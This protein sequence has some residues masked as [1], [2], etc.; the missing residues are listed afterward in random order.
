MLEFL[1]FDKT[2]TYKKTI[3]PREVHAELLN[4]QVS[5]GELLFDDDDPSLASMGNGARVAM[6]VD[7]STELMGPIVSRS[8]Q[9]P[10]G[11]TTIRVEDDFRVFRN[12][13]WPNPTQPIGSQTSEYRRHTGPTETVVKSAVTDLSAQLAAGWTITPTTG[14]GEAQRVEFRFHPLVDKLVPLLDADGLS[15]TI[16]DG[17]VDVTEG[18]LFPR[19]LTPDSGVLGDYTWS[20]SAPNATRVVVGGEGE[21]TDRVLQQFIDD[22]REIDWAFIAS[23]F[24]DSRMAQGVS[25][26][27]PD[28]AEALAEGSGKASLTANLIETS[29]F[30]FG[31]Y[32][33]GDRVRAQIG[34]VDATET[35]TQVVIDDTPT[36]G[37]TIVPHLGPI[38]DDGD[39]Q[40]AADIARLQAR[41]R[42]LGRR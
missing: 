11:T 25:D 5:F 22:D 17:V 42:D 2:R 15:L 24:K 9:G 13:L 40:L 21:G 16:R 30:Q 14:K 32:R 23:V 1:L 12:I 39:S 35:I 28:G 7:D 26:L 31:K 41:I 20:I 29:W 18:T 33:V 19:I 8:G 4:N 10:G 27:S 36:N 37:L 38:E 6:R 3:V 34:P